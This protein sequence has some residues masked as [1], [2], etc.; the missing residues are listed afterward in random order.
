[1]PRVRITG[2][3]RGSTVFAV[4]ARFTKRDG[5]IGAID[6]WARFWEDPKSAA[7]SDR[8]SFLRESLCFLIM[9]DHSWVCIRNPVRPSSHFRDFHCQDAEA[10]CCHPMPCSF[11]SGQSISKLVVLMSRNT[12]PQT[13][14][15][16]LEQFSLS[17]CCGLVTSSSI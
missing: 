16:T 15:A 11:L 6:A 2:A 17:E 3:V 12:K 13:I 1:M 5:Q 8:G 4:R 7:E 10:P 9:N 14:F